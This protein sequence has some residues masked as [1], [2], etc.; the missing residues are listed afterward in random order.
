MRE[1]GQCF[2]DAELVDLNF[3]GTTFTWWNKQKAT[4]RA[5]K[6]DRVLVNEK[7]QECFPNAIAYFQDPDFSDHSCSTVSI[8]P[9]L[10]RKK[11]PFKFF[12]YLLQNPTFLPT[13]TEDWFSINVTGSAMFRIS[14]K[15]RLLKKCI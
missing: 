12:N 10:Q 11:R 1:L 15:L 14:E 5:K 2:L 9:D 13:V 7:W 6:L 4:P 3:R 8:Q